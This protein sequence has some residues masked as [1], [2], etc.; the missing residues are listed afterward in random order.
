ME[1][2]DLG[3]YKDMDFVRINKINIF[4][5]A[6]QLKKGFT[7]KG[8][9]INSRKGIIVEFVS[10]DGLK[11]FG[12]SSPL[13]HFHEENIDECLCQI[14]EIRKIILS[15]AGNLS[16]RINNCHTADMC[17]F[18]SF[19]IENFLKVICKYNL[20]N[21]IKDIFPSVRYCFEMLY[22][23]IYIRNSSIAK[24]FESEKVGYI[25]LS[26]LITDLSLV[27][28]EMLE[29]EIKNH[30]LSS[31]KIKIGRN[32]VE[33]EIDKII[34]IEEIISKYKRKKLLIRLDSNMWMSKVEIVK[35]LNNIDKMFIDYVED[36]VE[37]IIFYPE[38]Y[39]S[40]G[41]GIA[42]DET[43][44]YF[45]DLRKADFK[46][47]PK[48]FLKAV[49]IKPQVLGGFINTYKLM[50]AA[51]GFN[52]QSVMSN[53]FETSLSIS[54]IA[55]FLFITGQNTIPAGLDTVDSFVE[56]VGCLNIKSKHSEISI[57]N[58]Y[59]NLKKINYS[60]LVKVD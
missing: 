57:N 5:F 8:G 47:Q 29:N 39:Q 50:K 25:N 12:E 6:Q 1:Y 17:G 30:S 42:V 3:Q 45:A 10:E 53:I 14:L 32:N 16:I 60:L 33:T 31:L 41:V 26:R 58:A 13:V 24:Y 59:D 56:D 20:F 21:N 2:K 43:L 40:T 51:E 18:E 52:I 15:D 55:V 9:L 49:I 44:K 28:M 34:N 4:S 38:I 22:F 48:N 23:N 46:K 35:L 37:D 36:P 27:D 19:F 7:L 11:Y 54:A